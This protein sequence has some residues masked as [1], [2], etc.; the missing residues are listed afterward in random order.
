MFS[1]AEYTPSGLS[2]RAKSRSDVFAACF[3]AY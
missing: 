3:I 2:L 1:A